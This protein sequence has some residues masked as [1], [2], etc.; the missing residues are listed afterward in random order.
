MV[1]NYKQD[2]KVFRMNVYIANTAIYHIFIINNIA[3]LQIKNP[4]ESTY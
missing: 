4:H 2:S 3:I 1:L